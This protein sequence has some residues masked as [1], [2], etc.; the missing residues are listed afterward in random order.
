M[1]VLLTCFVLMIIWVLWSN[2]KNAMRLRIYLIWARDEASQE[3]PNLIGITLTEW[4][5]RRL[6]RNN[7][8]ARY[9][10][11]TKDQWKAEWSYEPFLTNL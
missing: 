11:L 8:E 9:A 6:I 4:G 1:N 10:D 7:Q 5:A 2:I 3:T